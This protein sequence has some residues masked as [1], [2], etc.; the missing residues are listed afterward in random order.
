MA[1]NQRIEIDNSSLF[2][3]QFDD[4]GNGRR[5]SYQNATQ[6]QEGWFSSIMTFQELGHAFQLLSLTF[7]PFHFQ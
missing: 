4:H 2:F 5:L 3:F 7:P 1:M 6:E